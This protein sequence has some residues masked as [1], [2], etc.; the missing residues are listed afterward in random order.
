VAE[1]VAA[2]GG[3]IRLDTAA[4]AGATFTITLPVRG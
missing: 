3:D 4:G 2:H 1:I